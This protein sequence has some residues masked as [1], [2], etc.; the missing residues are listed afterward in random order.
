MQALDTIR[1]T[2][3]L[4]NARKGTFWAVG[5]CRVHIEIDRLHASLALGVAGAGMPG[6]V[7]KLNVAYLGERKA[8]PLTLR[9]QAAFASAG[10]LVSQRHFLPVGVAK[11]DGAELPGV[12]TVS[13]KDLLPAG[14]RLV[15]W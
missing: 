13:A 6:A 12:P 8:F 4:W 9:W 10:E 3:A 7:A 2:P 11:D 1:A 15:D 5:T 14:H